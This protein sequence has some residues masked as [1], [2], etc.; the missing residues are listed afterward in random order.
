MNNEKQIRVCHISTVHPHYDVRIFNRE[1]C[2]LAKAGYEVH[3]VVPCEQSVMQDGVYLHPCPLIKSRF[4]RML[5]VPWLALRI[6]LKTKAVIY[7]Y[8]DPELMFIGFV[9]KWLFNKK[10]VYDIHESV[11]RQIMSKYWLPSWSR[12]A[13]AVLYKVVEKIFSYGQVLVLANQ[14]SVPDYPPSAYLVRNYPILDEELIATVNPDKVN[15][16]V[17]LIVYV[18][19]VGI[20][21]GAMIYVELAGKLAQRGHN[22]RM[23]I[24]GPDNEGCFEKVSD[25]IK[26]LKLEYNV[27]LTG[28]MANRDAMK[29]VAQATI[30]LCLLLPVPNYTLCFSTKILE[31]MMLGTPVLASNFDCW[32]DFVEGERCGRMVDPCNIDEVAGV[33]EEMLA[34]RNELV[35]MGQ[36]GMAAAQTKYN[37]SSELKVLLKCYSDIQER[38]IN[39]RR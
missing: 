6:A 36:R 38:V 31:Y 29:L 22:F 1:C 37:W 33:C 30:G 16:E 19:G 4:M 34:G 12:K 28:P 25:R 14:R 13:V 23:A 15:S 20:I 39:R 35:A 26:E 21:R 9:L 3:L 5:F 10:V 32:R 17:P 7:H 2:S 24:V 11:P 8:H 27:L 18:G